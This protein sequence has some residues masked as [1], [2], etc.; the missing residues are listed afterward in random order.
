MRIGLHW[1]SIFRMKTPDVLLITTG[2]EVLAGEIVDTNASWASAFLRE[3]GFA[4]SQR[5]TIG[6]RMQDLVKAFKANA[7]NFDVVIVSGGLGPTSD[8]LSAA[9]AAEALAVPLL[10][11]TEWVDVLKSRFST[12]KKP[13][14]SSNFKQAMLPQGAER[15][16]NEIGT[17]CGFRFVLGRAQFFFTPG[18][19]GEYKA[20]MRSQV[21][22]AIQLSWPD[23]ASYLLSRLHVFGLSE[24]RIADILSDID[25]P[26]GSSLGFRPHLPTVEVK[27]MSQS[28]DGLTGLHQSITGK[29]QQCLGDYL[30][31][32]DTGSLAGTVQDLLLSKSATVATAESCSGGKL[33]D[34]MISIP[35]SSACFLRG[36]VSYSNEAKGDDLSVPAKWIADYGAVSAEVAMAMAKGALAKAG[37]HYALATSGISGPDGG[38]LEKPVG[39]L[40]VA[41]AWPGGGLACLYRHRDW[42]R[43]K[44]RQIAA[45]VALDIL[46]RKLQ[47]KPLIPEYD[48][49]SLLQSMT[50]DM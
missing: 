19:P 23:S 44:N 42:G 22:P 24:S 28:I 15:L 45:F 14:P 27:L 31:A 50:G 32:Q 6:D 18:V 12:R 25:L 16:E 47:D 4:V 48:T 3:H 46:R 8:D 33:A 7:N 17:A 21:L 35:G 49:A 36:Y 11:D 39:T 34:M 38:T 13:I 5:I 1:R 29:V 37:A 9:A 43:E 20:M 2:E 10:E 41:I 26:E 30:V 40:A